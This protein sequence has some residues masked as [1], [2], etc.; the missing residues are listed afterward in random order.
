[1]VVEP[2]AGTLHALAAAESATALQAARAVRF[3]MLV[4]CLIHPVAARQHGRRPRVEASLG[5]S[6]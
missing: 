3:S 4:S 2:T 5:Q 6:I 1:M